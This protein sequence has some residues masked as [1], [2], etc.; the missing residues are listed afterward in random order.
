MRSFGTH[1]P[2]FRALKVTPQVAAPGAESASMTA[3]LALQCIFYV[4]A[5]AE[6]SYNVGKLKRKILTGIIVR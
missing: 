5:C 4:H 6:I 1:G 2:T 3:L